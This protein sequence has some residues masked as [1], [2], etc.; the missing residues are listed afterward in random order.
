MEGAFADVVAD[1]PEFDGASS[2]MAT[3]FEGTFV[4]GPE[5][6]RGRFL[7]A[8]G[9]ELPPDLVEATGEEYGGNLSEERSDLLDVD[10]VTDRAAVEAE[11]ARRANPPERGPKTPAEW[12]ELLAGKTPAQVRAVMGDPDDADPPAGGGVPSWHY[13]V[14]VMDAAGKVEEKGITVRFA[15]GVVERVDD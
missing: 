8:L 11:A 4:Y 13:R 9:F 5:D 1:N 10:A 6:A 15:R 3:P 7:T 14:K 2:V 12:G